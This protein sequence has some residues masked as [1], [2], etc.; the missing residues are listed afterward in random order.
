MLRVTPSRDQGASFLHVE[1]RLSGPAEL[2]VLRQA[3]VDAEAPGRHVVVELSG[4]RFADDQ[5][6]AL[7]AKLAKRGVELVGCSPWLASLLG[8]GR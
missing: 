3:L 5:A 1:G 6:L 4:L 7:L 2:E 8:G